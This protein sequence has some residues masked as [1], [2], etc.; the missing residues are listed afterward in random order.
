MIAVVS[1]HVDIGTLV[2]IALAILGLAATLLFESGRLDLDTSK[3]NAAVE[4]GDYEAALVAVEG[5]AES[6]KLDRKEIIEGLRA[7]AHKRG[8][9]PN[10]RT[11]I[12]N[13]GGPKPKMQVGPG[14][15]G[16]GEGSA[17]TSANATLPAGADAAVTVTVSSIPEGLASGVAELARMAGGTA[18]AEGEKI[19]ALFA[20]AEN[21]DTFE[22]SVK[23]RINGAS[24][25]R[26]GG[27]AVRE[28]GAEWLGRIRSMPIEDFVAH[29][30]EVTESD[31]DEDF[32]TRV[33]VLTE[34]YKCGP[35]GKKDMARKITAVNSLVKKKTGKGINLESVADDKVK[36]TFPRDRMDEFLELANKS[37]ATSSA[38]VNIGHTDVSII[39][40]ESVVD[41]FRDVFTG[42]GVVYDAA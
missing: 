27:K 36:V 38:A 3:F 31:S 32:A 20:V 41:K 35:G 28:S 4:K 16:I 29:I 18:E 14:V 21:A 42:D 1:L 30:A 26:S 37:G 34:A 33:A 22:T 9:K 10:P 25:S 19:I 12:R 39:L 15:S 13:R 17:Q 11:G 23:D 24:T 7:R 6:V 8:R 40:P 5:V 2:A